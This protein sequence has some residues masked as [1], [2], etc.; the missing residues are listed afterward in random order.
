[1]ALKS[2]ILA[3]A[4]AVGL[5]SSASADLVTNGGFETGDFTGWTVNTTDF[6]FVGVDNNAPHSGT[7]GAYVG[8][9]DNTTISQSIATVAGQTYTVSFWLMAESDLFGAATP[10]SFSASF[11]GV[12]LLSLQDAQAFDYKFYTFDVTASQNGSLLSFVGNDAPAFLDLDDVSVSV[13]AAVP[14]PTTWAMLL[15][16]FAGVGFMTYRRKDSMALRVA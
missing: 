14:E 16:G 12:T 15:L 10:N 2:I 13:T 8:S 11:G 4:F 1:M 5:S 7:Y 9:L 3:A 6:S